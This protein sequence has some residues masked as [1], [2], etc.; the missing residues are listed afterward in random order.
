MSEEIYVKI[1]GYWFNL[2]NF[3]NHPGGISLLK[4]YN[5]RDATNAFNDAKHID[6]FVL[7]LMEQFEV[8]DNYLIAKLNN[9]QR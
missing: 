3:K 9:I 4:K 8:K 1:D 2:T 7:L 6:G 5:L